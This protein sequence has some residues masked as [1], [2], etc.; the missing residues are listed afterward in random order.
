M[1]LISPIR[2]YIP[3]DPEE[4]C[5]NPYDVI[6]KEEEEKLKKNPNSLIHL[7]L[8]EGTAEEIYE[9]AGKAY[10]EFKKKKII[11][12]EEKPSIFVYRQESAQFSHQGLIMGISLQDYEDGNIVKHEFTRE[13]PLKDRTNHIVAS[14][15]AAGLVWTVFQANKQINTLIE[16]IKK[17][18]PKCDF[19][20]YGYRQLLWQE[21]DL[22][23]IEKL[24]ISDDDIQSD[25]SR[26]VLTDLIKKTEKEIFVG[27]QRFPEDEHILTSKST[28]AD[29]L[30]NK[31]AAIHALEKA[32]QANPGSGYIASRLAQHYVQE[33][34]SD[35][36]IELLNQ[37]LA[38]N[39]INSEAHLELAKILINKD[40]E[41]LGY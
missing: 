41:Y 1:V 38:E 10:R 32:F 34:S 25:L 18:E 9:N 36:A 19:K 7:I 17:K 29:I 14:N 37:S 15:V 21:T 27:L 31:P 16:T 23:I 39:P 13:K 35:R 22:K 4:F 28:L 30:N 20:K 6:S 40:E 2:P 33:N 8:P 3:I 24:K 26:R 5:T 12:K 11:K